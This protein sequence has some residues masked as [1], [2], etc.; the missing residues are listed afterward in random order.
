MEHTSWNGCQGLFPW[1]I[2]GYDSR[3]TPSVS[4][5]STDNRCRESRPYHEEPLFSCLL[6]LFCSVLFAPLVC[7]CLL[8]AL[9]TVDCVTRPSTTG[10]MYLSCFA[11]ACEK[12]KCKYGKI[13]YRGGGGISKYG[14]IRYDY[15]RVENAS[16]EKW[17]RNVVASIDRWRNHRWIAL[18]NRHYKTPKNMWT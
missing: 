14:K 18:R 12:W 17:S 15:A 3:I 9:H 5:Y 16:T 4:W 13:K 7:F 2:Q 11:G 1:G 6:L 10:S 8:T